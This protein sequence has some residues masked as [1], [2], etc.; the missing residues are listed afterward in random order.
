[1]ELANS[2][3]DSILDLIDRL[4]FNLARSSLDKSINEFSPIR[5][6]FIKASKRHLW[7]DLIFQRSQSSLNQDPNGV[8]KMYFYTY[9]LSRLNKKDK[10]KRLQELVEKLLN[11][12]SKFIVN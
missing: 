4:C 1:M 11:L 12:D 9:E 6:E 8:N 5:K 3:N 7:N 10:S 2:S